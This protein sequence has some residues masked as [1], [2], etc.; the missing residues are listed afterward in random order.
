MVLENYVSTIFCKSY[1][2]QKKV[3]NGA[4]ELECAQELLSREETFV[5]TSKYEHSY[6]KRTL[7]KKNS[8]TS[9]SET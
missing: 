3:F 6:G 9:F 8:E 1:N 2:K 5:Q 4:Q 7:K